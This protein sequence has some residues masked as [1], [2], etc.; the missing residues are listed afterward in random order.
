L[1]EP[2]FVSTHR[3]RPGPEEPD[4]ENDWPVR[5]GVARIG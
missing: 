4:T 2:G 1:V 5:C 3:W